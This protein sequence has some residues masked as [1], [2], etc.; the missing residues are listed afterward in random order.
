MKDYKILRAAK[1]TVIYGTK[2][3]RKVAKWYILGMVPI[4]WSKVLYTAAS[5]EQ[6]KKAYGIKEKGFFMA[7]P[8]YFL[9]NKYGNIYEEGV[10]TNVVNVADVYIENMTTMF[11]RG[12][13]IGKVAK[14][15]NEDVKLY[16][17]SS[18]KTPAQTVKSRSVSSFFQ[19]RILGDFT[20]EYRPDLKRYGLLDKENKFW[21]VSIDDIL[22]EPRN[23]QFSA[24]ALI[25]KFNTFF[26]EPLA[27]AHNQASQSFTENIQKPIQNAVDATK[28]GIETVKVV[29]FAAG[30]FLLL[31]NLKKNE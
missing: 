23:E 24:D 31:L 19:K 26:V 2:G 28:K 6:L 22:I 16:R 12:S 8:V 30:L 1:E 3:A 21:W 25:A 17:Y 15:R 14:G 10:E 27:A 7:V 11:F 9:V 5:S 20:G 4:S 29:A 18:D 13:L